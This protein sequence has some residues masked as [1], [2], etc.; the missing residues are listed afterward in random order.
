MPER[1]YLVTAALPYANGPLHVGHAIGAYIPADVYTRYL[2]LKGEDVLYICGTDEHGTPITVTADAE[3]VSP[4]DVVDKYHR[5]QEDAFKKLNISFDNFSGT[6]RPA[7]YKLSQEFFTRVLEKGFVYEKTV[8]RPYCPSCKKFLPDR[9]VKGICPACESPDQRGDQCE[10]CGRQLEPHELKN[11]YCSICKG[12]PEM[13]QTKHWFFK[14]SSLSGRLNEWVIKNTQWP[15]NARNFAL[16]WIKEGL[17]DRAITR[18]INWGIPVPLKG[19]E[20]KVLYVWFDAPIG[21]ISSTME[22]AVNKGKPDAWKKYWTGEE[23]KIVH[24]IGKDNIPFH[25]IIWPAVLMAEG[26]YSLPWQIASNEFL[27]LE[28]RKMSTSRGWVVWLHDILN[29]FDSDA[30]RYYLISIAPETSDA[31]FNLN[32]FKDKVNNELIAT[33]GNFINRTLTFIQNKKGGVVPNGNPE[34]GD[35]KKLEKDD[36]LSPDDKAIVHTLYGSMLSVGSEI[37]KL[38]LKHALEALLH[39][40]QQGNIYFQ[41]KEPWKGDNDTTIFLCANLCRSLAIMMHPFLPDSAEK[42][43]KMLNLEGSV[44]DQHWESAGMLAIKPG[45]KIGAVEPLY[46]QIE[47]VQIDNFKSKYLRIAQEKKTEVEKMAEIDYEEFK[48]MDLRTGIIREAKPHPNAD[49]LLVLQ[50]DLGPLGM[51]QLVGGIRNYPAESLAGKQVIVIA[52][53]KPAKIRGVESQGMLLAADES[54]SP[55]LLTTD[56]KIE[57]GAKIL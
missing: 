17:E 47:D 50:V 8:E 7:H 38:K 13:R 31:D 44:K 41:K 36:S 54:G 3:G 37:E 20:G 53:L 9:Y 24:F 52:N 15:S 40:A 23:T 57:A 39:S 4:K 29:E 2:R 6:A 56:K 14:L 35:P 46:R 18:D 16:G 12:K 25:T 21:Y 43:W 49:K 33:L 30:L 45:H 26:S 55:V 32:E 5:I 34:W 10:A 42:V 22:W 48:K 11:A 27:N 51:R 19:A 1:R 28:G